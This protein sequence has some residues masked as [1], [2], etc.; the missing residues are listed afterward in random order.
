MDDFKP[1]IAKVATGAALSREE[2]RDA[3]DTILSGEVT[4][5]QAKRAAIYHFFYA[6]NGGKAGLAVAFYDG[7]RSVDMVVLRGKNVEAF[8]EAL[9]AFH[10][11]A[12]SYYFLSSNVH[13]P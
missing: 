7:L 3:F 2:A 6:E 9:P 4:N 11:L 12:G 5:A 13:L 8:N 1:F 10:A